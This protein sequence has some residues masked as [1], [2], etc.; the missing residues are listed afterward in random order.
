MQVIRTY[1]YTMARKLIRMF[2]AFVVFI[3]FMVVAAVAWSK[4]PPKPLLNH[5]SSHPIVYDK[6]CNVES[7]KLKN[8][9][10]LIMYDEKHDVVWLVLYDDKLGITRIMAVKDKKETTVWCRHDVC[11]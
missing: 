1:K 9:E 8:V 11:T 5:I 4:T 3:I 7:L 2:L 6:Q 10:C